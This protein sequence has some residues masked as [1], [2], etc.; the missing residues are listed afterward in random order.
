MDFTGHNTVL[1]DIWW[2]ILIKFSKQ[3]AN[4]LRE[5][6][7]V[8]KTNSKHCQ[9]SEMEL[10]PQVVASFKGELRISSN[11]SDETFCKNKQKLKVVHYFCK[12]LHHECLARF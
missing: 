4:T 5:K 10:F 11:I 3:I 1:L 12:K 6:L 8:T 2:N 7:M 9:T